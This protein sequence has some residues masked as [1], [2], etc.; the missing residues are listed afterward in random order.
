MYQGES[1]V[2]S[3]GLTRSPA[4]S[5]TAKRAHRDS[6]NSPS[7]IR[8]A[9]TVAP[10]C[11]IKAN[12]TPVILCDILSNQVAICYWMNIGINVFLGFVE[13]PTAR[14]VDS[15]FWNF[16]ALFVPQQHPARDMQDTFFIKDPPRADRPRADPV[17]EAAMT[18]MEEGAKELY[19]LPKPTEPKPRNYE[20][21]W[22]RVRAVHEG[23]AEGSIGYRYNWSEDE[24]LRLVLRTHT[25]A[26]S[27]WCLHRLAEDP[28]PA[29]YFSID[30][31]FRFVPVFS[32]ESSHVC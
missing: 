5:D 8:M 24:S 17:A 31:V 16:D 1:W 4:R 32:P 20:E 3:Y 22:N 10:F 28:R 30:R 26:V 14:Y 29:R 7:L 15:G 27:T 2:G 19:A 12:M 11:R 6:I 25:T 9:H 23:D 21:Y 18:A 13:M